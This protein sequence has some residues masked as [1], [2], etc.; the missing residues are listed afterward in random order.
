MAQ[1]S[2]ALTLNSSDKDVTG[3][4]HDF[5]V[6][7]PNGLNLQGNQW[8][9]ALET[10]IMFYSWTNVSA[11][12]NTNTLRYSSNNGATWYVLTI[13]DGNYNVLDI[14]SIFKADQVANTGAA[15]ISFVPNFNTGHVLAQISD[16]NYRLDLTVSDMYKLFGFS[17]AQVAAPLAVTTNSANIADITLG[18]N[19]IQICCSLLSN[20]QSVYDNGKYGATLYSFSPNTA[21]HSQIQVQPSERVYLSLAPDQR[22]DQIRMY[23]I[24]NLG[25]PVNLRGEIAS[26]RIH[27]RKPR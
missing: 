18:R 26:Y 27:L 23:L 12:Q 7:Y 6:K 19:M 21:P 17:P 11:E 22:V 15:R 1:P 24:D 16:P 20:S 8:E 14:D 10:G 9:I 25:R 4:S 5:T 13:P 2:Q 3:V